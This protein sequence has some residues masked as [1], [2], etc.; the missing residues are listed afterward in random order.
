MRMRRSLRILVVSRDFWPSLGGAEVML[1][2]LCREWTRLGHEVAVVTSRTDRTLPERETDAGL[3]IVRLPVSRVRLVG[4]LLFRRRLAR[5]VGGRRAD[6]AYVSMFKHAA[7][8]TVP[9]ARTAGIPVVV[10]A[11]GAGVTGDMAWQ[12]DA[13]GGRS[14]ARVCRTAE[15]FVA[16]TAQIA[17]ELRDAGY[18][19]RRT[20]VIPNGV[21]VPERPWSSAAAGA[22]QA[23]LG[24]PPARWIVYTGRLHVQKGLHDLVDALTHLP[25][26]VRLLLV[27][28]GPEREPLR[29]R[30]FAAGL[31]ERVRLAGAVPDVAPYL[32]A[33][34]VFCLP[35][36]EEG[37]SLSLLEAVGAGVPAVAS[38]IPANCSA[39]PEGCV[40][41]APIHDPPA[42]AAALARTLAAPS[43][44]AAGRRHVRDHYSLTAVAERHVTLFRSL[45]SP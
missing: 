37:L 4:T 45:P 36:Y 23:A 32:C 11:E 22:A 27:G 14:V 42:L 7:A 2:R 1:H 38:D 41:L 20:V 21:P 5:Q 26:D 33:A 9:A 25:A 12:R 43:G 29:R 34:S 28:D 35:S 6:V 31:A 16:P 10:R 15:R 44:T 40:V 39:L 13:R 19:A 30:A 17:G 24:L 3:E 18:D 8:A